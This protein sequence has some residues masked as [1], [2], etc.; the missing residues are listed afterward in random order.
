MGKESEVLADIGLGI[1]VLVSFIIFLPVIIGLVTSYCLVFFDV[2]S[3]GWYYPVII[4]ISCSIW[5][6]V[7]VL[8]L[9]D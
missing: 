5:L 7:Y 3:G 6:L 9:S 8:Y 4:I 2:I 1:L